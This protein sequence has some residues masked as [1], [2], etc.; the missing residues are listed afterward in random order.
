MVI[1]NGL[2]LVLLN[3]PVILVHIIVTIA[4]AE[5]AVIIFA[6]SRQSE[7]RG[8]TMNNQQRRQIQENV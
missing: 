7:I 4:F 3:V 6:N 8:N 1:F 2:F 5:V